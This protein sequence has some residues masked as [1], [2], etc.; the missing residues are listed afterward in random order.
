MAHSEDNA[1]RIVLVGKTGSGK[2]ATGNTLLGKNAFKSKI[3]AHA[4]TKTCQAESRGWQGRSL[5]VVD[6]PG[7]FDTKETLDTT[8]LEISKCVLH[9]A[10][11]PHAILM[12]VPLIRQTE[13]EQKTIKLIKSVFGDTAMKHMILLFT[14]KE[15]LGDSSLS[16]FVAE[17]PVLLKSMVFECG[18]RCCAFNNSA[19]AAEK[20]AQ[21][22][23]LVGLIEK[24][25]QSNGGLYFSNNI[26]EE[27]EKKLKEKEEKLKQKYTEHRDK[28][29]KQVEK[30]DADKPREDRERKIEALQR[31]WE[32]QSKH[33]RDEAKD[34]VLDDIVNFVN[35]VKDKLSGVWDGFW[36]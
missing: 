16:E 7:L 29:I 13:E 12:V 30:E 1:L 31:Q 18:G 35:W 10:P 5:H 2:S 33:A 9:S 22:Q 15:D 6:T 11:G 36:E 26:Y 20:E 21:V 23:E 24:M 27:M 8:C 17:A 4:V 3:A 19:G 34:G 25:V 32:E 28:K 14:R